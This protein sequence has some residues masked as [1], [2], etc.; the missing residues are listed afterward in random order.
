MMQANISSAGYLGTAR[1]II[2]VCIS[3]FNWLDMHESAVDGA[4][5]PVQIRQELKPK[6][7]STTEET[8][9][10]SKISLDA[11]LHTTHYLVYNTVHSG[12]SHTIV[13]G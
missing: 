7:S 11:R 13:A 12:S 6:Y 3:K 8:S 2:V 5:A 4:T 10:G 9:A 1:N